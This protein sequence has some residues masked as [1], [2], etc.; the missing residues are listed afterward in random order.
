MDNYYKWMVKEKGKLK[1][2]KEISASAKESD[3]YI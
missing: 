2:E 1:M 3:S